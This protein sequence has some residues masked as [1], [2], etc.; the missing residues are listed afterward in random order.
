MAVRRFDIN[1]E[2]H[3]A[4]IGDT[5]L[6]FVPELA[7]EEMLSAWAELAGGL[8]VSQ[9]DTAKQTPSEIAASAKKS[10]G[11]LRTFISSMMYDDESREAFAKLTLPDRVLIDL[12]HWLLEVYGLRPTGSSSGSSERPSTRTSGTPSSSAGSTEAQ[13]P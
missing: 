7:G 2:P 12:Q 3:V 8:D 6:R 4:E 10:T 11:L 13:T 1:T 5:E 9:I